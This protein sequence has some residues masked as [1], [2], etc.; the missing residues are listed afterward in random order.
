[1]KDHRY[2]RAASIIERWV[3][4][5]GKPPTIEQLV[6]ED[7]DM[8]DSTAHHC[9]QAWDA[10]YPTVIRLVARAALKVSQR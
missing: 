8:S 7:R 9:L 3:N 1:M 2:L 5:T 6:N 4:Q 10:Y